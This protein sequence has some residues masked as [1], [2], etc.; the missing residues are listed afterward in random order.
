MALFLTISEGRTGE[1][2]VPILGTTDPQVIQAVLVALERR[3]SGRK[4]RLHSVPPTA[5]APER[6]PR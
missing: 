2:P 3:I 1:E 6:V 4:A 5:P